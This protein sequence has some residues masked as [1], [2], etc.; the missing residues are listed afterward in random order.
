MNPEANASEE[1]KKP[2][3]KKPI[4]KVVGIGLALLGVAAVAYFTGLIDYLSVEK[5]NTLRDWIN[6]FG[7]IAPVIFIAVYAI[8]VVAFLPATPLTLLA[9]LVFGAVWGTLWA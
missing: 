8:T 3:Q 9:G 4:G 6:G 1:T 5:L 2:T 7:V